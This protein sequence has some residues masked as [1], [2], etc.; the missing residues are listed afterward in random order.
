[1]ANETFPWP[2]LARPDYAGLRVVVTS[3]PAVEPVTLAEAK[4]WANVQNP[5][6]DPLVTDLITACRLQ[7]ESD[8]GQALITQTRTA[9][10]SG[11]PWARGPL[12]IPYV[13]IQS[14]SSIQYLQTDGTLTTL[15]TDDYAFTGPTMLGEIRLPFGQFWPF[16]LPVDDAVQITYVCGYGDT[17]DKVP[18]PIRMAIRS[19][20]AAN[21]IQRES[22]FFMQ[23]GQ[24]L[25]TPLYD[26][27]LDSCRSGIYR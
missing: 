22:H 25:S 11:F 12:Q 23:G 1:M 2:R 15:S 7:V 16:T 19:L 3:P 8:L 9:Y 18:L 13:P 17:A 27:L 14:I 5:D 10:M 20:I 6:D 21:Y 26:G 4:L 24:F